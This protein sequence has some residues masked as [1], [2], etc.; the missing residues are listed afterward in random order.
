MAEVGHLA[1]RSRHQE[2]SRQ[3]RVNLTNWLQH[4]CRAETSSH[5]KKQNN[6]KETS[7]GNASKQ[8]HADD[9]EEE[10]VMRCCLSHHPLIRY[11]IAARWRLPQSQR[12][13]SGVSKLLPRGI[14]HAMPAIALSKASGSERIRYLN[15]VGPQ[16]PGP[17]VP[18]LTS[19]STSGACAKAWTPVTTECFHQPKLQAQHDGLFTTFK[20][21]FP[22]RVSKDKPFAI[23][24]LLVLALKI[25]GCRANSS[26]L[27]AKGQSRSA[28]QK[29]HLAT[30]GHK[31]SQ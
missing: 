23:E 19:S 2:P 9:P 20:A 13:S 31:M 25:A 17:R 21:S 14:W 8:M 27:R 1:A 10:E 5:P 26:S 30:W 11:F 3:Q 12:K 24:R 6:L 22:N 15:S 18:W 29:P 16:R 4:T 7:D 28:S